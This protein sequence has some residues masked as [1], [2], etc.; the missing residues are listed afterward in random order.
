MISKEKESYVAE[1]LKKYFDIDW[2]KEGTPRREVIEEAIE[3][4]VDLLDELT[5]TNEETKN[6]EGQEDEAQNDK[7]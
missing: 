3:A 4:A 2:Y 6:G 7:A 1:W 5:S